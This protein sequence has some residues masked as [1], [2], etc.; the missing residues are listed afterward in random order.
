M[1]VPYRAFALDVRLQ[2]GRELLQERLPIGNVARL[3][4]YGDVNLFSRQMRA[5]FGLP[6]SALR[7]RDVPLK[8]AP[9]P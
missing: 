8:P 6:P 5:H 3:L 2:R 9:L 7:D 4:G 1:G